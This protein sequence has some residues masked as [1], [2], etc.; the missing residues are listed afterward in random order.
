MATKQTVKPPAV[1]TVSDAEATV[2]RLQEQ[3][4]KVAAERLQAEAD[5]GKHAY[6]A[7]AQGNVAAVE[8]LDKVADAI[9]RHDQKLREIDLALAEAG[10][11]LQEARQSEAT[12]AAR[13]KA[14]EARKLVS[15][16]GECFPYLDRKLAEAANALIAINDGFGKLRALGLGPSDAMVRLNI[17]A[18]I[19]TWAMRLPKHFH[20][21]LRD[22]F[23]FLAPHERKTAEQYFKAIET[24]LSNS[25]RQATG[26]AERSDTEAA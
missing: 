5:T 13:Q 9:G 8:A 15:E 12:A 4:E 3:R 26:E 7:W 23:R 17:V 6:G 20:N 11:F 2:A 25:I 22:G 16:L 18:V 21:E 24:S 1:P 19:Q 14:E 10:R